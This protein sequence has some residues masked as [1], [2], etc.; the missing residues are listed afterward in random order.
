MYY[1][2]KCRKKVLEKQ[3]QTPGKTLKSPENFLEGKSGYHDHCVGGVEE[4]WLLTVVRTPT[5]PSEKF[6]W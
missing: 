3:V 2:G 1:A 4:K 6:S 5:H